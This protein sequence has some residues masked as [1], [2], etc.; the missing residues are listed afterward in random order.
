MA[1]KKSWYEENGRYFSIDGTE[2]VSKVCSKCGMDKLLTEFGNKE[3]GK[4]GV[5]SDCKICR[6]KY[7]KEYS[8]NNKEAIAEYGKEYRKNNKELIAKNRREYYEDNKE[9]I[10]EYH[11]RY[12]EENSETIKEKNK[13]YYKEN[14]EHLLNYIRIYRKNNRKELSEK[15][16]I[17]YEKRKEDKKEKSKM[18]RENNKQAIAIKYNLYL[19]TPKGKEKI[20]RGAHKRKALKQQSGGSYTSSQWEECKQFFDNKCAYSGQPITLDNSH[21]EH[22]VPISKGGTSYIWNLC[23]SLNVINLSKHNSD[24]EEWYRKQKYFTE[25]RLDRVYKWQEYSYSKYHKYYGFEFNIL[26]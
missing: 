9:H 6:S 20:R 8:E 15:K 21:V 19:K 11:I 1:K 22:I 4:F 23:L 17:Y 7:N 2:V 25:E 5:R 16:K 14:R 26:I 24:M 18:Y 3:G 12:R 13:E 10:L